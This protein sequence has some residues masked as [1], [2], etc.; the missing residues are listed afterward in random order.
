MWFCAFVF[1]QEHSLP[2][3]SGPAPCSPA[4]GPPHCT[5]LHGGPPSCPVLHTLGSDSFHSFHSTWCWLN[6]KSPCWGWNA[7]LGSRHGCLKA[8]RPAP[9][10]VPQTPQPHL[11]LT[12][13]HPRPPPSCPHWVP[14]VSVPVRVPGVNLPSSPAPATHSES[15]GLP[16]TPLKVGLSSNHDCPLPSHLNY[17]R[18]LLVSPLANA[19]TQCMAHGSVEY[20]KVRKF[21]VLPTPGTICGPKDTAVNQTDTGPHAWGPYI[22]VLKIKLKI[23]LWLPIDSGKVQTF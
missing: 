11:P 6:L 23:H 15:A 18:N 9:A 4:P 3:P 5:G 7:F 17:C 21:I 1:Q 16:R 12:T 13:L 10:A 2:P 14:S 8:R 22:L 19:S 20:T